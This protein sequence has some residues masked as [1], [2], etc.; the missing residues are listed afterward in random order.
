VHFDSACHAGLRAK[1]L[2]TVT[3]DFI[4]DVYRNGQKIEN[5]ARILLEERF[6][7][8][9]ERIEVPV[10]SGDWMVFHVV[11][12]RLRWGGCSYFA[13]AGLLRP[14]HYGFTS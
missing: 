12:N 1:Y 6:G 7:A 3:D 10:Y 2:V 8:T 9:V 5:P 13:A 14:G 11:N 4:V